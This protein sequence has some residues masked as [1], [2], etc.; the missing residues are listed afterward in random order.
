MIFMAA[1]VP[2]REDRFRTTSPA[3]SKVEG[4]GIDIVA[5]SSLAATKTGA[6]DGR[7]IDENV[8]EERKKVQIQV[9]ENMIGMKGKER[10]R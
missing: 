4:K 3:L 9:E 10:R 1:C 8:Q 2:Q 6:H 5:G 7:R